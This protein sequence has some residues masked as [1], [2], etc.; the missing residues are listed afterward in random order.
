VALKVITFDAV[1]AVTREDPDWLR[2]QFGSFPSAIDLS[3]G[4]FPHIAEWPEADS[5]KKYGV[6]WFEG[7][8]FPNWPAVDQRLSNEGYGPDRRTYPFH[9]A[10]EV[11]PRLDELWTKC[12][13]GEGP[14]WIF[15]SSPNAVWRHGGGRLYV[16]YVY[17]YPD[18]REVSAG[19]V[20]H[21][22]FDFG[23]L[24]SCE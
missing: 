7:E 20:E 16:P 13:A 12:Q 6:A 15:A 1:P 4:R 2:K 5:S 14:R 8:T 3:L 22:W 24:V 23:F 11:V 10:T 19:W 18:Y 21:D 17:V 9:L